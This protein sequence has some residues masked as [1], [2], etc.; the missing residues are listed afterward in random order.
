M[1]RYAIAQTLVVTTGA[2]NC[3]RMRPVTE[4][5][6]SSNIS[7]EEFRRATAEAFQ[8]WQNVVD[9]TLYRGRRR[10]QRRYRHRRA[11]GPDRFAY[12]NV[13]IGDNRGPSVSPI[14]SAALC[15]NPQKRW[16]LGSIGDLTIYDIVH[17]ISHEIGHAIG[18]DHPDERGHLTS[19]RYHERVPNLS[20]GDVLRPPKF[21]DDAQHAPGRD[22]TGQ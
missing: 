16:R 2:T 1:L 7:H 15:L 18:L 4:L 6:R 9:I 11:I 14:T 19:F 12:A 17:T 8:R 10:D 13:V 20:D 5:L 3:G 21:T 22:V